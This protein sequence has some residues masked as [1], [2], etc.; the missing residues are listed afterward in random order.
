MADKIEFSQYKIVI[1]D[2]DNFFCQQLE[3][4]F[5]DAGFQVEYERN[6]QAGLKRIKSWK[7]HIIVSDYVVHGMDYLDFASQVEKMAGNACMVVVSSH[8]LDSQLVVQLTSLSRVSLT[9]QKPIKPEDLLNRLNGLLPEIEI[10]E[11]PQRPQVSE[12]DFGSG[13]D[14]YALQREVARL[15]FEGKELPRFVNSLKALTR[16]ARQQPHKGK[17]LCEALEQSKRISEEVKRQNLPDFEAAF[18]RITGWLSEIIKEGS[19][20]SL[21]LWDYVQ[22]ELELLAEPRRM[23]GTATLPVAATVAE[24]FDTF[25]ASPPI[26]L[27]PQF[28]SLAPLIPMPPTSPSHKPPS[29]TQK[30]LV[31]GDDPSQQLLNLGSRY[32]VSVSMKDSLEL[33]HQACLTEFFDLVLLLIPHTVSPERAIATIVDTHEMLRGVENYKETPLV[34]LSAIESLHTRIVTAHLS[35]AH[36]ICWSATKRLDS[37]FIAIRAL[38]DQPIMRPE[39][40]IVDSDIAD[41]EDLLR[42]LSRRCRKVDTVRDPDAVMKVIDANK[43]DIVL[44]SEHTGELSGFDL[45]RAIRSCISFKSITV[46]LEVVT[47]DERSLKGAFRAGV[48]G[49]ICKSD[50]IES[51]TESILTIHQ[52]NLMSR[53]LSQEVSERSLEVTA[54][55]RAALE[56]NLKKAIEEQL[57]LT[58]CL[59]DLSEGFS[60]DFFAH[61]WDSKQKEATPRNVSTVHFLSSNQVLLSIVGM[62]KTTIERSLDEMSNVV[63]LKENCSSLSWRSRCRCYPDDALSLSDLLRFV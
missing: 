28:P 19:L 25:E 39:V 49:V 51:R 53:I 24:P 9:L 54:D 35:N 48:D 16:E 63:R 44:V 5:T 43:P 36:W 2:S 62:R 6:A 10:Q 31:I 4:T 14:D 55:I 15:H 20:P 23:I 57:P 40:L 26:P 8:Y 1:V 58:I 27:P 29:A 13:V 12:P 7:P 46:I 42:D 61:L 33:A 18:E 45:C 56:T 60:T 47:I 21:E 34:V 37:E 30:F 50:G 17:F 11:E 38:A 41:S 3:A 22:G 52:R 59:V 32:G